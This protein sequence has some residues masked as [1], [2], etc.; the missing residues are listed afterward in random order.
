M[1]HHLAMTK[2]AIEWKALIF[3]YENRQYN[4][5]IERWISPERNCSNGEI[6]S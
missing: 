3:E 1:S 6:I 2:P 4:T 5:N